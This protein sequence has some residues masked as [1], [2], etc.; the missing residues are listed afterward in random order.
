MIC[1]GGGQQVV[2]CSPTPTSCLWDLFHQCN[3]IPGHWVNEQ[4]ML[5][6]KVLWN[7]V[8]MRRIAY[9]VVDNRLVHHNWLNLRWPQTEVTLPETGSWVAMSHAFP[10]GTP[11]HNEVEARGAGVEDPSKLF[12]HGTWSV[13]V[14]FNFTLISCFVMVDYIKTNCTAEV[15]TTDCVCQYSYKYENLHTVLH[16]LW[17]IKQSSLEHIKC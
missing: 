6:N 11:L 4:S 16:R 15:N 13:S 10:Q 17:R 12:H 14:N 5:M 3:N 1:G 7:Y 2:T 9:Y 8:E